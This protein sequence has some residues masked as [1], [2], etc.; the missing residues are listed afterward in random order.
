MVAQKDRPLAS[1]GY[2]WRLADNVAYGEP[3]LAR[4][5][6]IHAWHQREMKC[7]MTLITLSKIFFRIF[8]PLVDLR[9]QHSSGKFGV[10]LCAQFL[11]NLVCLRQIF[12]V[13]TLALDEVGHGVQ[14]QSVNAHPEPESHNAQNSFEDVRVVEIQ[15]RLM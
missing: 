13:R 5:G 11:Q 15:I 12:I 1:V 2:R 7:H 4:D 9:Q 3:I 14:S 8:R 10:D 6:H